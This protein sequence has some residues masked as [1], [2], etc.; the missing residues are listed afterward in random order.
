VT[1]V[2]QFV[3]Q[4]I[5]HAPASS[6]VPMPASAHS[7]AQSAAVAPSSAPPSFALPSLGCGESVCTSEDP[8]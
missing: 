4:S 8:S 3:P 1:F 7:D 5:A 2:P 6:H